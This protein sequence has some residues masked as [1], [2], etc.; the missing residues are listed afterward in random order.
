LIAAI[1]ELAKQGG[2]KQI[3]VGAEEKLGISL[4]ALEK[5]NWQFVDKSEYFVSEVSIYMKSLGS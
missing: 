2:Y 4:T 1:E 5:R 3:F